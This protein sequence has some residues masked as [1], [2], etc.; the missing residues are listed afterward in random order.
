MIKNKSKKALLI[1]HQKRSSV[2]DV[3]MK[4]KQRNY[5]L[6]IRRPALGDELPSNM[7]EHDLAVIYGGPMSCN[8]NANYIKYE[9][10]WINEALKLNKPF[11]GICLG[12]QMLAKNLGAKVTPAYDKSCEIGFFDIHPNDTGAKIFKNQKTFF[13]WHSEG[14]DL[15]NGSKLL[16]KGNKF[17]NQAFCYKN[18]YGIQFHPEV[19]FKMHLMWLYF[20][21]Y[22][23]KEV[24]AQSRKH[25]LTQRL[26][27]GKKINMWLDN[28]LDNY[29]LKT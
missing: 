24:G 5:T 7:N 16:A 14:F 27:Y 25:Q 15:P 19:N 10:E 2:G 1:V 12:A 11:L 4:L 26:K 6:D 23:L 28:F 9:I 13:Q 29:L 21:S 17:P 3:G 22:R 18:A 8:D 20:A